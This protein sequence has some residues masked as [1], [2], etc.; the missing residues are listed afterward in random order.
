M[1]ATFTLGRIAGIRVGIHQTWLLAFA[2]I[3]WTLAVGYFPESLPRQG[4]VIY[5][6]L[7]VVG[8]LV[9]FGS[10]LVHEL[11][12]SLV[13]R[14]RGLSVDSITLF[15]FGGVS[16]LKTEATTPG[17]EFLVAV[18]GPLTSLVLAAI[19]W[20]LHEV[21][22]GSNAI[23]GALLGYAAA[24]NLVL[25]LFNLVPGFP[26]DG[27]RVLRSVVWVATGSLR[28]ATRTA[29]YVG[30]TIGYLL[31]VL[32]VFSLLGGEVLNG[33]WIAFIGWFLSAAADGA[34]LGK[35]TQR[36]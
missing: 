28:R 11:S 3:S 5:I 7:G 34:E 8:S 26:L 27:G 12:H 14:R 30:Q 18:V 25:G 4:L 23:G 15:I 24:A 32:G 20:A 13:A 33:V 35:Q 36:P 6:V 10:V 17:D 2:L 31:V 29:S 22:V 1:R 19:A 9:L 21:L 16:N